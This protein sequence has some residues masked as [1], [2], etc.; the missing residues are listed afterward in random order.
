MKKEKPI[1]KLNSPV[2]TLDEDKIYVI[3]YPTTSRIKVRKID[4][5]AEIEQINDEILKKEERRDYLME[6]KAEI[7]KLN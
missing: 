2:D 3:E 7:D 1:V 5:D 6:V 4:L